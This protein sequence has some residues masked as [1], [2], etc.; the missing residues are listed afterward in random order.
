[1]LSYNRA[2][3]SLFALAVVSL[4]AFA[5]AIE[6][7]TF[8]EKELK[9]LAAGEM[10]LRDRKPTDNR[11]VAAESMAIID[12][13][14]SEVWPVIR[15][16][17]KYDQFM[18]RVKKTELRDE[19]GTPICHTELKMP[20]PIPDLWSDNLSI[21]REEPSGRYARGWKMVR[22]MYKR[23]NGEWRLVPWGDDN[24]KTLA[25]YVVDSDPG[26]VIPDGILKSAQTGSL[27][28]LFKAVRNRV[29]ALREK[30][31]Q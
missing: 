7:P 10:V 22:G 13:P 27:P 17:G 31:A 12:A 20:W 23:N 14:S 8:N 16:C 3:R 21:I 6:V 2:M 4:P 5:Q 11:G 18:P 28:E 15:D 25:V 19:N 9:K 30:S 29:V 24:Q 1:M 26:L